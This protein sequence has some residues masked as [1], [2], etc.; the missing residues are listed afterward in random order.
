MTS[1][2][3]DFEDLL[4]W[5]S[6]ELDPAEAARIAEHLRSCLS[7][8][9]EL[10][11]IESI[12]ERVV[13]V[14]TLAAQRSFHAAFEQRQRSFWLRAFAP[15]FTPRF[16]M[17]AVAS[18]LIVALLFVSLTQFTPAARAETLLNH[19][20][21]TQE[22]ESGATRFFRVES[23]SLQCRFGMEEQGFPVRAA[24][25]QQDQKRCQALTEAFH[26]AGWEKGDLLS[27]W[28]FQRWRK[29]LHHKRDSIRKLTDAVEVTTSTDE[30]AIHTATL[31]LRSSD[32]RPVSGRYE[33]AADMREETVE[34]TEYVPERP[35]APVTT[36]S[37]GQKFLPHSTVVQPHF[38]DPLDIAEAQARLALH[39][40]G[41]D[42]S[43]LVAVERQSS[44]VKVWGVVPSEQARQQIEEA[45]KAYPSVTLAIQAE[46]SQQGALPWQAY[47]GDAPALAFDKLQSL[48]P[49]NIEARQ[50]L[51][52]TV[53]QTSR[54][55]VAE[56]Q[57]RDALLCLARRIQPVDA[58]QADS[59]R[60]AAVNLEASML[61]DLSSLRDH[62]QPVLGTD[63]GAVHSLSGS[64]AMRLYLL[65]HELLFQAK[66]DAPSDFETASR[67]ICSLLG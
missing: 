3:P 38:I 42:Q 59:L 54:R 50:Q 15:L 10:A 35:E 25:L 55:L 32:D 8:Q 46:N 14:N 36:A 43:V 24:I 30:G 1:I 41:I 60:S 29:G 52:N 33:F 27:G 40:E 28:S 63:G 39:R 47:R 23:P 9:K 17:A 64:Q 6:G 7:C 49:S 5:Q 61:L 13:N 2:H 31:R 34:V 37:A 45:L 51:L 53:D 22:K 56:A 16:G 12:K 62:L 44:A 65:L 21:D 58:S 57:S 4:L 20:I 48:Y 26:Y 19:A 66:S 67:E 11:G 18:V